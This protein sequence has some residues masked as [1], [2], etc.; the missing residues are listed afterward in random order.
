MGSV[1]LRQAI[2]VEVLAVE[3]FTSFACFLAKP[4]GSGHLAQGLMAVPAIEIARWNNPANK[5][6]LFRKTREENKTRERRKR[7]LR[8]YKHTE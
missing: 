5:S 2:S 6:D 7:A 8:R 4:R 3:Q 1:S